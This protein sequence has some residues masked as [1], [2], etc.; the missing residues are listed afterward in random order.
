MQ[1]LKVVSILILGSYEVKFYVQAKFYRY[2]VKPV[3]AKMNV[4]PFSTQWIR[5]LWP[6]LAIS[7]SLLAPAQ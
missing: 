1:M 4:G 3:V 7:L 6:E 5:I 2:G